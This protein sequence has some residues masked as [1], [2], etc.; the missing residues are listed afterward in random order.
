MFADF[1]EVPLPIFLDP[2]DD[3]EIILGYLVRLLPPAFHNASFYW[4]WS[5]GHG[6]DRR[7]LRAH[8]FF[9]CSEKHTDRDYENWARSTNGEA[10][11]KI[12]DPSVCRTVQPN[13]VAAPI[14]GEGV[15][16]P[17]PTG[18]MVSM[19]VT[20]TRCRLTYRHWIGMS[21][22]ASKSEMNTPNWSNTAC[23]NHRTGRSYRMHR[24]ISRLPEA[25]R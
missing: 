16:D 2:D 9:W 20:T 22:C 19:S 11:W 17:V 3:P 23:E 25:D 24:P 13:Y 12:L 15:D 6:L 1:D 4:Q 7:S 18:A 5:C 10:T 14:L 8:L 21:M